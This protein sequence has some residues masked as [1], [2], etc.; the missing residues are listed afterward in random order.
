M[1]SPEGLIGH[2]EDGFLIFPEEM[3]AQDIA[4][5]ISQD[6]RTRNGGLYY[7][8]CTIAG[9]HI[10]PSGFKYTR[11]RDSNGYYKESS[12]VKGAL[13]EVTFLPPDARNQF[14]GCTLLFIPRDQYRNVIQ[15]YDAIEVVS[16]SLD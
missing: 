3:A 15:S 4:Y 6:T 13:Y 14:D 9:I 7:V 2:E 16:I 10:E 11:K 1:A 12:T 8:N 5:Y